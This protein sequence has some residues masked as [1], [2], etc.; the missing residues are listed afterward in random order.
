[1]RW[2]RRARRTLGGSAG[3]D[4]WYDPGYRL[5]I[6]S[7]GPRHGL[8]PR[9]ADFVAWFLTL[10]GFVHT[11]DVH[12]P[13]PVRYGDLARVHTEELL[14]SLTDGRR[15]AEVFHTDPAEF[16]SD[17]VMQAIRR[18]VGGTVEAARQ[19]LAS[20]SACLN[21]LGGFHHAF[22]EKAGGL[23][24]VNDIAV[25]VA[26]LRAEGFSGPISVI[27]LDAHPPDGTTACLAGDE[28][29]WIGSLSGSDWGPLVG[30]DE[31][32]LPPGTGDGAYL[33]ALDALLARMPSSELIF[34]IA[35][36]DV[37]AGDRMGQLGLSLDGARRRDLA[38]LQAVQGRG[39]VWLPG[40]GYTTEAWKVL[41]GTAFALLGRGLAAIPN[42]DPLDLRFERIASHLDPQTLGSDEEDWLGSAEIEEELGIRQR[43]P[44][45]L[46]GTYTREG[47]LH[48]LDAYGILSHLARLGYRAFRVEIEAAALGERVR[49]LG[50]D[51]GSQ[52]H[53]LGEV[54]VE[55][56]T[57]AKRPIVFVHWLTL[58]HPA[59][60]FGRA[61]P[62]LPGQEVPGLGIS[63]EV[64]ELL[65]RAAARTDAHG[66]GF[67]PSY[68]HTAW[69][70][71][72]RSSFVD[73]GRQGRMEA[74]VRDLGHLGR[75]D[76]SVALQQ[77]RVRLN[78]EPYAWEPEPMVYWLKGKSARD[79]RV[80][81]ELEKYRFTLSEEP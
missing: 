32:V 71:S 27:D 79:P 72:E 29:V 60:T 41:A 23:C 13:Q 48:A 42:R 51:A 16:Q 56:K 76:L 53:V 35:G 65:S 68:F 45:R 4:L 21:L 75:Y 39:S 33:A 50:S 61:R 3:L 62:Q 5:P 74:L 25:A 7:L 2:A 67:R 59:S 70:T 55:R 49:V 37:I 81:K 69:P 22:P 54:V 80:D 14:T 30:C 31:T 38:V 8:E 36:G 9:R 34:I 1:M 73:P 11:E 17:E 66:V 57:L 43:A 78:G 18:A 52:E 10:E 12:T 15:L 6:P 77:G 63:V 58:R 20:R 24:P 64:V 47:L 44:S 26:V 28:R 40:G 46:L 19:A